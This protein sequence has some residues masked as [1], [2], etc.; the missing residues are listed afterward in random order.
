MA[1]PSGVAE[2][3]F[4]ISAF[5]PVGFVH[6]AWLKSSWARRLSAPLDFGQTFR[7]RRIFGPNK[8]FR[9]IAVLVPGGGIAFYLL[10]VL[11]MFRPWP[12]SDAQYAGLGVCAGLG[13]ILGELPSSF[14]K[15]QLDVSPGGAPANRF[16]KGLCFLFDHTDSLLGM[17][18]AVRLMRPLPVATWIFVIAAGFFIHIFFSATLFLLGIKARPL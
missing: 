15:R 5:L 2:A 7:G 13:F 6:A 8:M 10:A 4:L 1:V 18:I 16:F 17:L 3:V 14:I 12:L 9:G 11:A